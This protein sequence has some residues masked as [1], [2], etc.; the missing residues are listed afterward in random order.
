VSESARAAIEQ[1]GGSITLI[2][3]RQPAK[4]RRSGKEPPKY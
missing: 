4:T 3:I 1:A 2:E